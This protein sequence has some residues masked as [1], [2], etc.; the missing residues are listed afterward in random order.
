MVSRC[1]VLGVLAILGTA[2]NSA[3]AQTTVDLVIRINVLDADNTSSDEVGS[4][5]RDFYARLVIDGE[6]IFT[7]QATG[8]GQIGSV[9]PLDP[10]WRITREFSLPRDP[11]EVSIGIFDADSPSTDDHLDIST[12]G[13][14]VDFFVQLVPCS[15]ITNE[16]AGTPTCGEQLGTVGDTDDIGAIAFIVEV[17]E[18]TSAPGQ[19]VT[20]DHWNP[21]FSTSPILPNPGDVVTITARSL[22]GAFA[23][24]LANAIEIWVDSKSAPASAVI[25]A[26]QLSFSFTPSGDSFDY[27]CRV[28]DA[29]E[30]IFS[31]WRKA[32]VQDP[33]YQGA[34]PLVYTAPRSAAIDIVFVP[35]DQSYAGSSDPQFLQD[36]GNLILQAY[37][38]QLAAD[39]NPAPG[40]PAF[41]FDVFLN[42]QDTIN[43]WISQASGSID[44]PSDPNEGACDQQTPEILWTDVKALL[45]TDT[46]RDCAKGTSFTSEPQSVRTVR[47]ETGHRPFG[48]ADEYC[49]R[50]PANF[51]SSRCDGGYFE[52]QPFPNLHNEP[53]GCRADAPNLGRPPERCEE[54]NVDLEHWVDPDFST[55]EP[56][57]ND[58][59]VDNRAP[60]AADLRRIE[61]MFSQCDDSRC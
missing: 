24:R 29:P 51:C 17:K 7:E 41:A 6:E 16:I 53:D 55:S 38:G 1:L 11:V 56:V 2:W 14:N 49:D 43:F 20:C 23:P 10:M 37:Y 5:E 39:Q 42:R 61:W 54:F 58:L 47:H 28:I 60:Q 44:R 25:G 48:L 45:H 12:G 19:H 3:H 57:C 26:T 33:G 35:D 31:G 27:G 36:V 9:F 52:A 40:L 32:S 50:R 4:G 21:P 18:P 22:D 13:R 15:I 30:I 8:G 59:M 46:L 34:I